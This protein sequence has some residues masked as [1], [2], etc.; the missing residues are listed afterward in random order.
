M[1]KE[2]GKKKLPTNFEPL[3]SFDNPPYIQ[4]TDKNMYR[5]LGK[6]AFYSWNGESIT[7]LTEPKTV[8]EGHSQSIFSLSKRK[9]YGNDPTEVDADSISIQTAFS[10]CP[11][12]FRLPIISVF[13]DF[14][15]DESMQTTTRDHYFF[16]SALSWDQS[17]EITQGDII[18]LRHPNNSATVRSDSFTPLTIVNTAS[19]PQ[20]LNFSF[21]PLEPVFSTRKL[22]HVVPYGSVALYDRLYSLFPTL[23]HTQLMGK[24]EVYYRGLGHLQSVDDYSTVLYSLRWRKEISDQSTAGTYNLSS[25]SGNVDHSLYIERGES[26]ISLFLEAM[27]IHPELMNFLPSRTVTDTFMNLVVKNGQL[28]M[29]QISQLRHFEREKQEKAAKSYVLGLSK[30]YQLIAGEIAKYLNEGKKRKEKVKN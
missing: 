21:M 11:P 15:G 1:S 8:I 7:L 12:E 28:F 17:T 9:K 14:A 13:K 18:V 27:T 16:N 4:V 24:L 25:I 5:L 10:S 22:T 2:D 26:L 30:G 6:Q 20:E 3:F 23:N 29:P 19:E